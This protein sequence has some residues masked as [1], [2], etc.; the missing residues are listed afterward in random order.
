MAHGKE[1]KLLKSDDIDQWLEEFFLDPL[2]SYFDE[3][4]FRID[5]FETAEEYI[6]E[7]LLP[8]QNV[9]DIEINLEDHNIRIRVHK[10]NFENDTKQRIIPFPF[11]VI[12]HEVSAEFHDDVIEV[13]IAKNKFCEGLNRKILITE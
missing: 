7:A 9:K 6:I 11:P 4:A 12:K 3:T 10:K 1:D 2:T 8:A 13:F 5:L